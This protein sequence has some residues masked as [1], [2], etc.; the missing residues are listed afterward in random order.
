MMKRKGMILCTLYKIL[1]TLLIFPTDF[2]CFAAEKSSPPANGEQPIKKVDIIGHRGAAGLAPENTLS[3]FKRACEIGVD[4][5]ELDALLTADGK[6][7]VHHDYTL[8]PESTRTPDGKWLN[9]PGP[10][11]KELTLA[12]LKTYDVGRL[13]PNTGYS[14]RY[15][16]Q[17][18]VDGERIPTPGRS[19]ITA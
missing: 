2:F 3:A 8:K 10:L 1:F 16:E 11:I 4:A 6:I 9:R 12:N 14:H 17:Q 5:I 18:P 19:D 15:P 13:K 7:V